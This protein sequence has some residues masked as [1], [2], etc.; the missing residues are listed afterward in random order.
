M[1]LGSLSRRDSFK[2]LLIPF[3]RQVPIKFLRLSQY[4]LSKH[5][6]MFDQKV[7]RTSWYSRQVSQHIMFKLHDDTFKL[8]TLFLTNLLCIRGS[9]CQCILEH[10]TTS[11]GQLVQAICRVNCSISFPF[12]LSIHVMK[13]LDT[14]IENSWFFQDNKTYPTPVIMKSTKTEMNRRTSIRSTGF[15]P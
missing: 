1:T 13:T 11:N 5:M 3:L 6:K 14:L 8:S 2:R 12:I 9:T 10:S 7:S 4:K 15:P